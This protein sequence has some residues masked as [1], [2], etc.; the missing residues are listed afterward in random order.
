VKEG[1]EKEQGGEGEKVDGGRRSEELGRGDGI[2][3]GGPVTFFLL[4]LLNLPSLT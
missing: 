4:G 3:E 1:E 2:E